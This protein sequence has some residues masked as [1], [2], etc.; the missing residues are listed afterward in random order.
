MENE[1]NNKLRRNIQ[2]L[3]NELVAKSAKCE[4]L[5]KRL[6]VICVL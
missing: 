3:K 6:Q 2:I 5:A 1:Q 4:E